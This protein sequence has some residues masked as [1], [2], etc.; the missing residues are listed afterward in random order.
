MNS[1][2]GYSDQHVADLNLGTVDQLALLDDS[3]RVT[4]DVIFPVLVH[5]G[6][7]GGLAAHKGA[8]CLTAAFR[9]SGDYRLD[10]LRTSLSLGH[11][12]QE[13]KRLSALSQHIIDAHRHGVDPDSVVLVHGESYLKLGADSICAT[14]KDGF[15]DIQGAEVE[16]PAEGSDIAHNPKP[17]GRGDMFLDPPDDIVTGFQAHACFLVI[18][19]HGWSCF[20]FLQI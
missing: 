4:G 17:R 10:D 8:A 13:H 11:I 5:A 14:H 7:L 19:C 18:Y 3:G 20:I 15:L 16:H 9:D 2:R 12:V 1:R 6:H